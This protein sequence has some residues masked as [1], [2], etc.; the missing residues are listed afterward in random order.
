MVYNRIISNFTSHTDFITHTF[1]IWVI[2]KKKIAP[3][4]LNEN[5]VRPFEQVLNL[6]NS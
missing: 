4:P 3:E 1:H 6:I 5:H 2:L